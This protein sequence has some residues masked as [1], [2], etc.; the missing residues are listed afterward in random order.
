MKQKRVKCLAS[1]YHHMCIYSN[2]HLST[3][4]PL[5][6]AVVAVLWCWE[7]GLICRCWCCKIATISDGICTCIWQ[8]VQPFL[9]CQLMH[10]PQMGNMNG[11]CYFKKSSRPCW[12]LNK[13]Q[14]SGIGLDVK[15]HIWPAFSRKY[16]VIQRLQLWYVQQYSHTNIL[17]ST[18]TVIFWCLLLEL[19]KVQ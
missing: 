15:L 1:W 8:P 6:H 7:D 10:M 9:L 4:M 18:I 19:F 17:L 3:T 12:I 5:L 16:V 2:I 14:K 13:V 11:H